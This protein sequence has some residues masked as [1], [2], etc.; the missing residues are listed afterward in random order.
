MEVPEIIDPY[1]QYDVPDP[2]DDYVC[3]FEAFVFLFLIK[4][5]PPNSYSRTGQPP[6]PEKQ[7]TRGATTASIMEAREAARAANQN[8]PQ[9][10]RGPSNGSISA[11][12]ES[13]KRESS[14]DGN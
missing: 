12:R 14:L 4:N 1:E 7:V 8:K 9:I 10:A 6:E 11:L 5:S 13:L 3:L 2:Y